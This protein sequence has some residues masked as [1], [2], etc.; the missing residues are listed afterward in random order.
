MEVKILQKIRWKIWKLL[1][2]GVALGWEEEKE[3]RAVSI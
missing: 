3:G 2:L 1:F